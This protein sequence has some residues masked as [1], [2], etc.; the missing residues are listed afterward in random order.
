MP[1]IAIRFPDITVAEANRFAQSL[2]D[3]IR[4]EYPEIKAEQRREN[5]ESQDFGA[6]L[7]LFLQVQQ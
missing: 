5:P 1:E 2:R 3:A 4:T 6:T 7:A